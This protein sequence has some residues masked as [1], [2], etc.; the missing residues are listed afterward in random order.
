[1]FCPPTPSNRGFSCT[2]YGSIYGIP[3][4]AAIHLLPP[5]QP[6]SASTLL[7]TIMMIMM[8]MI[9]MIMNRSW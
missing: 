1:M 5:A 7:A 6:G 3:D 8:M 9:M 4:D 2:A